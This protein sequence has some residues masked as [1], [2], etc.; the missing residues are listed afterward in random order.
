VAT[1][2][3]ERFVVRGPPRPRDSQCGGVLARD[4]AHRVLMRHSSVPKGVPSAL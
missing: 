4:V 1:G 2:I 3:A